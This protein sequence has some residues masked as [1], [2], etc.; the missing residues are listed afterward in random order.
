MTL[1]EKIK[2]IRLFRG[3]TQREFGIRMGFEENSADVRIA[4]YETGKRT[5]KR[6][7]L[8]AMAEILKVNPCNF[9][10][11]DDR[12]AELAQMFL[13]LEESAGNEIRLFPIG[14]S[15]DQVGVWIENH[16]MDGF[17][18]SWMHQKELLKEGKITGQEYMEWKLNR[19]LS[20]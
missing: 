12:A 9:L 8:L 15:G 18:R 2:R 20:K 17:L 1:G 5:P 10:H 6:E 14:Q 13:W 4:Q 16:A 11:A 3:M 19:G 7:A